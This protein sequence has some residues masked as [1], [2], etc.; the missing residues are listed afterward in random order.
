MFKVEV[1]NF[2]FLSFHFSAQNS[3][4]SAIPSTS[5]SGSQEG[6]NGSRN[7]SK[8]F[9]FPKTNDSLTISRLTDMSYIFIG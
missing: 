2:I 4:E 9:F 7:V 1:K 5:D 8:I 6:F 3:L